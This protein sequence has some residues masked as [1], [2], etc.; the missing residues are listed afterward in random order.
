[1]DSTTRFI[2]FLNSSGVIAGKIQGNAAT[3]ISFTGN[4]LDMAEYFGYSPQ[5]TRNDFP[6][7]T[8][9]CQGDNG[10]VPCTASVSAKIVGIISEAPSFIGGI[11]GDDKVL[12]G[13]VGQLPA[14]TD[15]TQIQSGDKV[16]VTDMGKVTK[17]TG[18]AF[19]VGLALENSNDN[20]VKMLLTQGF[21]P[22][23]DLSTQ[24]SELPQIKSQLAQI[25]SEMD[26]IKLR[27]ANVETEIATNSANLANWTD[28]SSSSNIDVATLSAQLA[29][30]TD[31]LKSI[32]D[33]QLANTTIGGTL[34]VG[35]LHFDDLSAEIS[36]LNGQITIN[37]NL[38]VLGDATVSG[39]LKVDKGLVLIDKS[40][41]ETYCLQIDNGEITKTKGEC[42]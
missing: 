32:G 29:T 21:Y 38:D 13:L 20:K 30:F 42:P 2:N 39:Q 19:V 33:T 22:D 6:I 27:L 36:S 25:Q 9:V 31:S 17:A 10:V 23:S 18:S 3:T 8:S 26:D 24:L 14:T 15:G 34:T 35:L 11:E 1:M 4:G 41:G 12:V 5:F 28:L 7:G 40:T 16:T 37:S